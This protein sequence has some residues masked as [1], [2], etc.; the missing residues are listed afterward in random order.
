LKNYE[1]DSQ[2]GVFVLRVACLL[3]FAGCRATVGWS[4]APSCLFGFGVC[5]AGRRQQM[6]IYLAEI[7]LGNYLLT[8]FGLTEDEA[9]KIVRKE[10]QRQKKL[11]NVRVS[12]DHPEIFCDVRE[13]TRNE[14]EWR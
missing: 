8:A 13:L 1:D 12:F 14:C 10:W 11:G 2:H 9:I 4:L 3:E 5:L 7:E 6:K